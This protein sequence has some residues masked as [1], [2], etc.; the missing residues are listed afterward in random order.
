MLLVLFFYC[1]YVFFLMSE[2]MLT[3]SIFFKVILIYNFPIQVLVHVLLL[4]I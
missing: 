1:V 2:S 3:V 4:N